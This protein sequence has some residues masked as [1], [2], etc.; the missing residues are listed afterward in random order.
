MTLATQSYAELYTTLIGWQ[1]YNQ[2][3]EIVTQTGLVFV[4]FITMLVQHLAEPYQSQEAKEAYLISL[5]RVEINFLGMVLVV[6]FACQP[7]FYLSP[8][9]LQFELNCNEQAAHIIHTPGNTGTTYDQAFPTPTE[10]RVPIWWYV[11]MSIS[12][13]ITSEAKA[14]LGCQPKLR[15]MITQVDLTQITDPTLRSEVTQFQQQCFIPA[16]YRFLESKRTLSSNAFQQR[17]ASYL[18]QYGESDTEWLGSHTFNDITG[19]YD[20]LYAT[21]PIPGFKFQKK[22]DWQLV[23]SPNNNPQPEWGQPSCSEWWHTKKTGLK[24]KLLHTLDNKWRLRWLSTLSAKDQDE[25]LK[26]LIRP[27]SSL[28]IGYTGANNMVSELSLSR[29]TTSLGTWLQQMEVYPKLYAIQ[30]GAP[31]IRALLLLMSYAMLPLA[32]IFS[33]YSIKTLITGGI[34]LFALIF[35][36]YLWQLVEWIDSVLIN[37]L[38]PSWFSQQSPQATLA[39]FI[40]GTMMIVFPLFWFSFMS[41]LGVAAGGVSY[42]LVNNMVGPSENSAKQGMDTMRKT[43]SLL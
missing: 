37:A 22:R 23:Q 10:T 14:K 20:T 18:N 39:D 9:H 30:Q 33:R 8:A 19:F 43:K 7:F 25:I 13:G 16:R 26:K 24:D 28:P 29:A 32:L 4:P 15:E 3:W 17:F 42:Q 36:S 31:I 5:R 38:Y 40:I 2:L 21:Q 34:L 6:V 41:S 35:W 11:V 1:V 27:S 12:Q